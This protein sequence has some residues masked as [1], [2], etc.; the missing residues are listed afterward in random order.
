ML[1]R[2]NKTDGFA[3]VSCAWA[4]PAHS[5][6]F[7]FCENGAKATTWEITNRRAE[8]A[9]FSE[10]PVSKLEDWPDH[11]LEELGRLTQPMRWDAETDKYLPISWQ[12]AF[13]EIGRELKGI[14]PG[15]AVFYMSGRGSLETAYMYSL[16]ARLYGTNNLPDSS[17]MCH[18]TTS[19]ALPESIGVPVGTVTLEDFAKTDCI[20]FFGQN[21]G[22]NAPRMLHDLQDAS[23]RGV[24]IVTFNPLRERGLE[25]FTNP[26]A[27]GRNAEHDVD[28]DQLAVSSGEVGW[29][30]GRDHRNV[31]NVARR[32]R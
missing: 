16:L 22:S 23:K 26:Q 8:P 13:A 21:V 10:H 17:N 6:V 18:E 15:Q 29:R 5:H 3:C 32:R 2:Q 25:E 7:E 30:P 27:P 24:P 19:V 4:K 31:Q 11:D 9:F 20:F 12:D 14:A 28:A 1:S